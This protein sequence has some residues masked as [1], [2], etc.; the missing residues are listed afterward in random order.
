VCRGPVHF[1]CHPH[2]RPY[3]VMS[4]QLVAADDCQHPRQFRCY[5]QRILFLQQ[6]VINITK[7]LV[8]S[9]KSHCFENSSNT[10]QYTLETIVFV[11]GAVTRPQTT[12][13]ITLNKTILVISVICSHLLQWNNG[14]TAEQSVAITVYHY[15][16]HLLSYCEAID[17]V[18]NMR[19]TDRHTATYCDYLTD[20]R[21]IRCFL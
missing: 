18:C 15:I 2:L 11:F 14:L 4:R 1:Q 17:M 9:P 10:T 5:H 20:G 12:T 19:G 8:T 3:L 21:R 13:H 16:T 7:L 6:K